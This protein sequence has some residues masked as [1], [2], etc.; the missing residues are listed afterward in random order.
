MS[1]NKKGPIIS[2]V[3]GATFF[4]IPYVGLGLSVIP[5]LGFGIV[6]FGAGKMLF[7][8]PEKKE[9][10]DPNKTFYE[11]LSESKKQNAQIYSLISKIESLKLQNN[12]KEIHD[13][14]SKIIDTISKNPSKLKQ[15]H[16]FFDYYLPVTVK[17]LTKYDLIENQSL[18]NDEVKK[19]MQ[20]TEKMMEKINKSFKEQ[21]ANLYQ[22]EMIDTDAE[23]KVFETMLNSEGLGD[24]ND[25][26]I[27]K[28]E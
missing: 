23:M 10:Q 9:V 11:I 13:N 28:E 3:L 20:S 7:S 6:A 18:D 5:S 27:T 26:N 4:A 24:I 17:I 14:A 22:A 16:S 12:L 19:F 15:A 2:A 8:E 25:F 1:K 21:L